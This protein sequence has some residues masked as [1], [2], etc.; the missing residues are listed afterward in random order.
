MKRRMLVGLSCFLLAGCVSF[1][2]SSLLNEATIAQIKVG[3]TTK[4]Q[5]VALLG[6]PTD[7]RSAGLSG[8]T[9]EWW[10]Y[11]LSTSTINPL[12]YLFLVGFF[13][14]GIGL[15]D[16]R[17]DL[18]LVFSPDGIVTG[19][20]QQTTSY[21]MGGPL[22]PL[23]VTSD[24]ISTVGFPGQPTGPTRYADQLHVQYP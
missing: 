6:E 18:N 4:D 11:S 20:F 15:P 12:E 16:T 2:D 23:S 3:Q 21:D 7:R 8:Y 24:S 13:F 19:L 10:A 17:R 22:I 5:V 9:H 1:G 14:N